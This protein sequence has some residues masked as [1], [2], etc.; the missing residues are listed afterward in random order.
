MYRRNRYYDPMT[1]QFTQSDP[2]GIAGGLNAYGFGNGDPVSYSDPYGLCADD[3]KD[4]RGLCPGGWDDTRYRQI[5]SYIQ[6]LD[7]GARDPLMQMLEGG[8]IRRHGGALWHNRPAGS[9][10]GKIV[11]AEEF[12]NGQALGYE[13]AGQRSFVLAHEYGH[14]L[15]RQQRSLL[16]LPMNGRSISAYFNAGRG[17]ALETHFQNDAQV[18]ACRHST[19][20][21]RGNWQTDCNNLGV[22]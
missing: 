19:G 16:Y 22:P 8:R 15:Q 5:E 1:G 3:Q 13:T 21:A 9:P 12:F 11:L 20:V 14:Q 7:A 10:R 18:Y 17:S 4:G 2:I 6:L